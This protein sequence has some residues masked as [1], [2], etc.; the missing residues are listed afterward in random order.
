MENSPFL[1][2][3]RVCRVI[4]HSRT[5]VLLA[6]RN[7]ELARWLAFTPATFLEPLTNHNITDHIDQLLCGLGEKGLTLRKRAGC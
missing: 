1:P 2:S 6:A 3:S 7:G 4:A 5:I